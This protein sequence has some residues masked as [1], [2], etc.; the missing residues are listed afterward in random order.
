AGGGS[1][2]GRVSVRIGCGLSATSDP[3]LAAVEASEDARR[4]L[5]GESADLVLVFASGTHL[6]EPE[7]TLEGIHE[8]LEPDVL[9]G[10]GAG[11]VLGCGHEVE[12][13][14]AVAVWAAALG[15]GTAE[16]FHAAVEEIDDSL[17]VSGV[18]DL[19]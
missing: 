12:D 19:E 13:G 1:M 14:T 15:G 6:A 7:S 17:A 11:G 4:E 10:C 5:D 2:V 3:R 18:P 9:V 8:T 16:P